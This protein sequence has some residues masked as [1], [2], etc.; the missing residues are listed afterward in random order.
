[1]KEICI[2]A[3]PRTGTNHLVNLWRSFQSHESLPE[4][5]HPESAYGLEHLASALEDNL[6]IDERDGSEAQLAQVMRSNPN[7]ALDALRDI[8]STKGI[9]SFSYKIFPEHL[10][11]KNLRPV[12]SRHDSIIVLVKRAQIDSFISLKKALLLGQW[13]NRDT[14]ETQ[15]TLDWSEF[16]KFKEQQIKWYSLVDKILH[17]ENLPYVTLTYEGDI[18]GSPIDHLLVAQSVARDLGV[19]LEFNRNE[20][21]GGLSKQDTKKDYFSKVSNWKE[22]CNDGRKAGEIVSLF[23]FP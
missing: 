3:V 10:A 5:F 15:V 19:N 14:T 12:L 21:L 8:L 20:I 11:D 18:C 4:I 2:V 9:K 7:A 23:S 17:E 1:M 6:K 22:F 13:Y 16:K